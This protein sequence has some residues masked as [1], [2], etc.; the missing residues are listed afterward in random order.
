V[1]GAECLARRVSLGPPPGGLAPGHAVRSAES[2][3]GCRQVVR[4]RV[5]IPPFGGSNPST[6]AT[7]RTKARRAGGLLA[8]CGKV[9]GQRPEGGPEGVRPAGPNNPSTPAIEFVRE[10][11]A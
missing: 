1:G 6:P 10:P 2:L 7:E 8:F 4:Q 9:E 3:L 11:H 5:L